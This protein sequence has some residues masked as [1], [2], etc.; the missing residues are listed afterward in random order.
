MW[1]PSV[2][3]GSD[4]EA[5][6]VRA[7]DAN[8][9]YLLD[10]LDAFESCLSSM[11]SMG[12]TKENAVTPLTPVTIRSSFDVNET[13]VDGVGSVDDLVHHRGS[14]NSLDNTDSES[15]EFFTS[16]SSPPTPAR[17]LPWDG[18]ISWTDTL[19][20][21]DFSKL[22][23]RF[24]GFGSHAELIA[25]GLVYTPRFD[26]KDAYR[27][28]FLTKLPLDVDMRTLLSAIRGGAVYSAHIMNMQEYS[29]HHMG[30]VT[31][32]RGKD[33]SAYVNFATNHGVYFNDARVDVYLSKTP[34]YPIP[35]TMHQNII[36]QLYSR[37]LV[38][39]GDRD[40]KRYSYIAKNL[41]NKM[42]L[43][44]EMGDRMTEN[45]DETE[46]KIQLSSIRAADAAY[47]ILRSLLR[48]CI[49]GFSPDPC[50]RPLPGSRE[51]EKSEDGCSIGLAYA[52]P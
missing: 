50:A 24:S 27:T 34:T 30:V 2:F 45:A 6:A 33:A 11:G 13:L 26:D 39:R 25:H 47:G 10:D 46:V 7:D 40:P 44:F 52:D 38:I 5:T 16:S 14:G 22:E 43:D 35:K 37:C 32:V 48:E 31:F 17:A 12:S 29:G 49:V 41:K 23:G 9:P 19:A 42:R 21:T 3:G 51:D 1:K 36:D 4:S 15:D 20:N 18:Y 28:V 8:S